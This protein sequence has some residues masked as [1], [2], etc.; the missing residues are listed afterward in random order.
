[1]PVRGERA[2]RRQGQAV[3]QPDSSEP[4]ETAAP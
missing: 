4:V 1:M 2:A 3:R